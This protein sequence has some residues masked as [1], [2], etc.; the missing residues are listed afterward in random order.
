MKNQ[1]IF[2]TIATDMH[3]TVLSERPRLSKSVYNS[4]PIDKHSTLLL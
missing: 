1:R 4:I 3:K 2:N